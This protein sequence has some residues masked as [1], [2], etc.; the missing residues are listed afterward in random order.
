MPSVAPSRATFC[1]VG[2]V[3]FAECGAG[4]ID[5]AASDDH[6]QDAADVVVDGGLGDVCRL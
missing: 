6:A 1:C 5:E 4:V 3:D 2:R